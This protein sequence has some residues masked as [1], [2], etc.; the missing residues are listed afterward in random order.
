MTITLWA[1]TFQRASLNNTV[2][3][4]NSGQRKKFLFIDSCRPLGGN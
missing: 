2:K 4:L 3:S 1:P